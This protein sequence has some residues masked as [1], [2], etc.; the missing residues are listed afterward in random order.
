MS[1]PPRV[2]HART[3]NVRTSW[4]K[5]R[6][7]TV[8]KNIIHP[9]I[10][11]YQAA[12]VRASPLLQRFRIVREPN[13]RLV[14]HSR[15]CELPRRSRPAGMPDLRVCSALTC[16]PYSQTTVQTVGSFMPK[17]H[18]SFNKLSQRLYPLPSLCVYLRN[19]VSTRN[20]R[21]GMRARVSVDL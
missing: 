8:F 1:F 20:I 4:L 13:A 11:G 9:I 15:L 2:P 7:P 17:D 10:A 16:Q 5:T 19:F 12:S 3:W 21:S 6:H 18:S 14:L